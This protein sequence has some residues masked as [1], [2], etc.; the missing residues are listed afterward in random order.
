MLENRYE[1]YGAG[2]WQQANQ[3]LKSVLAGDD[4]P[5]QRVELLDLLNAVWA[6]RRAGASP[7]DLEGRV[8]SVWWNGGGREGT[9][10]PSIQRTPSARR[11]EP[12]TSTA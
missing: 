9:P 2:K 3:S 12:W 6:L 11:Q 8:K 10:P 4:E 7:S 1:P 5:Q